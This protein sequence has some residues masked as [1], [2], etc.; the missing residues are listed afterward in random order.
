MPTLRVELF[1]KLRIRCGETQIDCLDVAKAQELLCY[2]LLHREWPHPRETLAGLLW[3]D[4]SCAQSKKYL[5]QVLWQL[6]T[7][8]EK[9]AQITHGPLLLLDADWIQI[10]PDAA[11]WLDVDV[12][13]RAYTRVQGIAG[14]SL[15]AQAARSV[16][17]AVELYRRD[18][19]DGWYQ[20][21]C[22]FERQRLQDMVMSLLDKLM[23]YCEANGSY[24]AGIEYGTCILRYDQAHE[25]TH[26]SLMRLLYLSGDRVA[27][28]RQYRRCAEAL[29]EELDV[30]PSHQTM[31]LYE[32][33][34]SDT[35]NL[36][37]F[38]PTLTPPPGAA[39]EALG[40]LKQLLLALGDL[41]QRV[42][43]NIQ[44]V[45]QSLDKR[46]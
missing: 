38:E 5:R 15:D 10:N 4:C 7:C 11:L 2:L 27:A 23:A 43:R 37:A 9:Q 3:G 29:R 26:R 19:L 36:A 45:E 24:E 16:E 28:L 42:S 20:D 33:I 18:L 46:H 14:H 22:I 35:V 41:Q 25:R 12:F 31:V 44:A 30:A 6:Q 21:W 34:C 39:E 13:E 1:G 17:E 8:I 40:Q 32:Q